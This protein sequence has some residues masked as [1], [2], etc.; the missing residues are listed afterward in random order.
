MFFIFS[1]ILNF[2]YEP[3]FW[4]IALLTWAIITKNEQKRRKILRGCL[5]F[6]IILTN[7]FIS[8]R[9]FEAWEAKPVFPQQLKDTF[10][11]GIVLGGFTDFSVADNGILNLNSSANRLTDAIALYKKEKIRKLLI[12]GGD[13]RL[14]GK[15]AAEADFVKPYLNTIGVP[16]S[17]IIIENRSRN[18][19][20]NAVFTK[21]IVDSLYPDSKCVLITSASH[22]PRA[23]GC[24][25]KIGL[26]CQA[27]PAQFV[28]EKMDMRPSALFYPDNNAFFNWQI[29]IK[30][31]I[32]YIVYKF[33][34]YI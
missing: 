19:R 26:K 6:T 9:I 24:F 33:Q 29:F 16:D 7:P 20:E 15:K 4:L 14:M 10:D 8:N 11:I 23:K 13:G 17:D 25:D 12:T 22:M 31:W 5:L 2:L 34:G 3:I 1:K 28:A 30:E 32:G 21:K 18:T 27:F